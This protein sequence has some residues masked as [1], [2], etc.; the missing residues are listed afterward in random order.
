MAYLEKEKNYNNDKNW[1]RNPLV[2]AAVCSLYETCSSCDN[3]HNV[4]C[5]ISFC[6]VTIL[7]YNASI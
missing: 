2:K 5:N 1:N 7:Q 6:N 3:V 4:I